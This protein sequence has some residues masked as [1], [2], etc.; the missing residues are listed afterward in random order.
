MAQS[1]SQGSG[2]QR[3]LDRLEAELGG[4]AG[5][6][7]KSVFDGLNRRGVYQPKERCVAVF[8][9]L[10]HEPGLARLMPRPYPV[11]ARLHA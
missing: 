10:A 7:S 5:T 3:V 6:A 8:N 2:A 9:A 4:R 11:P 1:G